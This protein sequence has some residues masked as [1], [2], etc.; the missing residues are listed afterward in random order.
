MRLS[1]SSLFIFGAVLLQVVAAAPYP[2]DGGSN[3]PAQ[4]QNNG[5]DGKH[6]QAAQD[7]G[8]SQSGQTATAPTGFPLQMSVPEY[9]SHTVYNP[10]GTVRGTTH[11]RTSTKTYLVYPKEP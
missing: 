6:N 9:F 8:H 10:D 7:N 1:T 2:A 11:E 5:Q 4:N 3:E